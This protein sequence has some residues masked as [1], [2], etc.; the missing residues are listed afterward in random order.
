MIVTIH[1][2]GGGN[3]RISYI[4]WLGFNPNKLS[5]KQIELVIKV[6]WDKDPIKA[7]WLQHYLYRRKE[8]RIK[9]AYKEFITKL[10]EQQEKM[11]E[12]GLLCFKGDKVCSNLGIFEGQYYCANL[13]V[14]GKFHTPEECRKLWG[15]EPHYTDRRPEVTFEEF[16]RLYYKRGEK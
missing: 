5:D 4:E 16:K 3:M 15:G 13:R 2:L 14:P 9:K 7:D 11:I 12:Q 10:K 1:L 6:L 8:R